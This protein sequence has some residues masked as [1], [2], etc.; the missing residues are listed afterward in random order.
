MILICLSSGL[1]LIGA[2]IMVTAWMEMK[3]APNE[4]EKVRRRLNWHKNLG[5]GIVILSLGNA[6][7]FN[8][9]FPFPFVGL[10]AVYMTFFAL[11]AG[12]IILYR[13][14]YLAKVQ[15]YLVIADTTNGYLTKMLILRRLGLPES[16]IKMTFRKMQEDGDLII[17]NPDKQYL[18][19]LIFL[20]R[21]YS[22]ILPAQPAQ[23][24]PE[25]RREG[26]TEQAAEQPRDSD[27][28]IREQHRN[29]V[30]MGVDAVNEALLRGS[31][32]LGRSGRPVR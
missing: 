32:N 4:I 9:P 2:Y 21:S 25:Q 28:A 1:L 18:S 15:E 10:S 24:T 26:T 13:Y 31:L 19:E 14:Y 30:E 27:D 16:V 29:V 23:G 20:V 6:V 12:L 5:W 11:C 7:D 17:L 8:F 22:G 3:R